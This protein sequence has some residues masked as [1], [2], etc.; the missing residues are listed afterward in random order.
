MSFHKQLHSYKLSQRTSSSAK[1]TFCSLKF[2]NITTE[3]LVPKSQNTLETVCTVHFVAIYNIQDLFKKDRT[4]DTNLYCSL[5]IILSTVPFKAV[6]T[7]GDAPFSTFLSL[8]ECFLERT[9]CD[10]AQFSYAL[11]RISSMV[12]KRRPFKVVLSL[13]NRKNFAGAKSGE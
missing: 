5:Y 10:G 8:L 9:I 11:S 13:G 7:T 12:W 4:F 1:H 2:V 3:N 6:P